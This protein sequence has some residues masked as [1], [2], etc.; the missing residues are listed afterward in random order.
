MDTRWSGPRFK[1]STI[2]GPWRESDEIAIAQERGGT[3]LEESDL[4]NEG[5]PREAL[6]AWLSEYWFEQDIHAVTRGLERCADQT[7]SLV[8]Q[9]DS[10]KWNGFSPKPR[11]KKPQYFCVRLFS[12]APKADPAWPGK[13]SRR[14]WRCVSGGTL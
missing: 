1:G 6:E 13:L 4:C 9:Y 5:L 8:R 10:A 3:V 7:L 12:P 2:L 11:G 14:G